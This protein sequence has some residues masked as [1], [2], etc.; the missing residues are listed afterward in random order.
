MKL[1]KNLFIVSIASGV[2]FIAS[3]AFAADVNVLEAVT[4]PLTIGS[5]TINFQLHPV[6]ITSFSVTD[7]SINVITTSDKARVS[8]PTNTSFGA[9]TDCTTGGVS[10]IIINENS[11][12]T[13]TPTKPATTAAEFANT[14]DGRAS[15]AQAPLSGGGGGSGG[16][17]IITPT[18]PQATGT[19]TVVTT[20]LFK[21]VPSKV[22]S[23]VMARAILKIAELMG[24]NFN[25][26]SLYQPNKK[27]DFAFMASMSLAVAGEDCGG[28][29]TANSCKAAAVAAGIIDPSDTKK[30]SINV[31]NGYKI[32]LRASKI[33]LLDAASVTADLRCADVS[34]K[35][36]AFAI[37]A[38][39]RKYH[40]ASVFKGKK[41]KPNSAVSRGY[42]AL[43]ASRAL[44]AIDAINKGTMKKTV[45]VEITE[46][47]FSP[48]E[49]S[50]STGDT[51]FFVNRM[52]D[53]A[54]PASAVHPTHEEL[55]GFDA[56]KGLKKGEGYAFTF[57]NAGTWKYHNHLSPSTQGSIVVT[58]PS[59]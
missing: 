58:E 36:S 55:P 42:A 8:G 54:W 26:G 50:I 24:G 11:N 52:K 28:K 7:S 19:T 38:T 53:L 47:G 33:P 2:F 1:F 4:I 46:N 59:M 39:A 43:Y 9:A 5:D 6:G 14:C 16:G 22:K 41:C 12:V 57:E 48:S 20:D 34:K 45:T 27:A 15:N 10:S 49:A 3:T 21:D 31:A 32:L 29:P 30:K 37:M 35:S 25:F 44:A 51:V 13:L 23:T 56:K 17:Q 40:I 18:K